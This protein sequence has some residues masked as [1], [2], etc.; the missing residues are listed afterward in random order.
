MRPTSL[1]GRR[2]R[3]GSRVEHSGVNKLTLLG[4]GVLG[5]QIAWQSAF[6]GKTVVVYDLHEKGL[7]Q[8]RADQLRYAGIC[9]EGR[10]KNLPG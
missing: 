8:C 4:A 5:G 2:S 6:K 1:A 7:E 3:E 9:R 10:R